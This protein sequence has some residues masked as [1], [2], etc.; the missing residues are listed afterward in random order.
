[1]T[2]KHNWR[3]ADDLNK[4]IRCTKCET[5]K[6]VDKDM[7]KYVIG[8]TQGQTYALADTRPN[9][10]VFFDTSKGP[11]REVLRISPEG[12]TANPDIHVDEAAQAVL[13]ALDGLVKAM[14]EKAVQEKKA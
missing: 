10:I 3:F 14:I 11:Q 9:N 6:F 12:V 13:R 7:D 5:T 8:S 1:M 2:C 4:R